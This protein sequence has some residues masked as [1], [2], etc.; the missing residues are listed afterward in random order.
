VFLTHSLLGHDRPFCTVRLS[1]PFAPPRSALWCRAGAHQSTKPLTAD[2][3]VR[4]K[5]RTGSGAT[6]M[7]FSAPK[8][9]RTAGGRGHPTLLHGQAKQLS[10]QQNSTPAAQ[11]WSCHICLGASPGLFSSQRTLCCALILC[12]HF[13][14]FPPPSTCSVWR[15]RSPI[16]SI[17][18]VMCASV[19]YTS[20]L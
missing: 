11:V 10:R 14:R 18:V 7:D 3:I 13:A 19:H 1:C 17:K 16:Q 2:E 20:Q 9:M 6:F 5:K 12:A 8:N 15:S 4:A